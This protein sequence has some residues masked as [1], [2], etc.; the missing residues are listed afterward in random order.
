MFDIIGT[1]RGKAPP[2][3]YIPQMLPIILSIF[4]TFLPDNIKNTLFIGQKSQKDALCYIR[5][6][7]KINFLAIFTSNCS[8]NGT[9]SKGFKRFD[10]SKNTH[11]RAKKSI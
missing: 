7:R 4:L 6:L 9:F 2:S 11:Y 1:F 8:H 3:Q 10:I 5:N